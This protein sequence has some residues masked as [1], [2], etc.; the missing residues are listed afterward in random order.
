MMKIKELLKFIINVIIVLLI[1][2]LF[3]KLNTVYCEDIYQSVRNELNKELWLYIT[4][5]EFVAIYKSR[6][7]YD[8]VLKKEFIKHFVDNINWSDLLNTHTDVKSIKTKILDDF[9][10]YVIK[11]H[12]NYERRFFLDFFSAFYKYKVISSESLSMFKEP[13]ENAITIPGF[14]S[15]VKTE[16]PTKYFNEG[17]YF[18]LSLEDDSLVFRVYWYG[19]IITKIITKIEDLLFVIENVL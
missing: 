5:E 18:E 6:F 15:L 10:L 3:V 12:H 1:L 7:Y 17:F 9:M 2:I 16:I 19:F 11:N 13:L 8:I 14:F 4:Q